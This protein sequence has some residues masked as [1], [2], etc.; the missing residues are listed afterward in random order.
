MKNI[1]ISPHFD[2][3]VGS[4]G[5]LIQVLRNVTVYTIFT[6]KPLGQLSNLA[7]QLHKDWGL[8]DAVLDRAKENINA[9]KKLN[10]EFENFDFLDVVY[11]ESKNKYICSKLDDLFDLNHE[12]EN[13]LLNDIYKAILIKISKDD[14]L[15][16]PMGFG[17]HIDHV[18]VHKIGLKLLKEGFCVKFYTD[19]SYKSNSV[20]NFKVIPFLFKQKI[21]NVKIDACLCYI[22]QMKDLFGSVKQAKEYFKSFKEG[23]WYNEFY[24]IKQL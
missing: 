19:F 23:E 14:N 5:G 2:D 13:D 22:S 18:L 12:L 20:K 17:N 9:C 15:Y 6:K 3:A 24:Y 21:L 7:L 11:R 8:K 10:I 16:F 4:C 1:F